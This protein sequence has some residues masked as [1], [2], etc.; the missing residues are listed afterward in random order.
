MKLINIANTKRL[1]R[2]FCRDENGKQT[3]V[4]DDSFYPFYYEPDSLGKFI[5]YDGVKLRK[6]FCSEPKEALYPVSCITKATA[7]ISFLLKTT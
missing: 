7:V 1:V 2:L 5:G 6:V 4:N 3:I